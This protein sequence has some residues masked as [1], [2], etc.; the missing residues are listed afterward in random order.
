[1]AERKLPEGF[2]EKTYVEGFLND[3]KVRELDYGY[4]PNHLPE[5]SGKKRVIKASFDL[6]MA[7]AAAKK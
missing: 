6:A 7:N 1:M 4:T 5:T 2:V 3:G